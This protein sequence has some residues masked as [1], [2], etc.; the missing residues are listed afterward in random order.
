MAARRRGPETEQ[1]PIEDLSGKN[2]KGGQSDDDDKN[3]TGSGSEDS[4][5]ANNTDDRSSSSPDSTAGEE[6]IESES[7]ALATGEDEE[8]ESINDFLTSDQSWFA[9]NATEEEDLV[10][11]MLTDHVKPDDSPVR[12][13]SFMGARISLSNVYDLESGVRGGQRGHHAELRNLESMR[14][15]NAHGRHV[16]SLLRPFRNILHSHEDSGEV[17]DD[18]ASVSMH[19]RFKVQEK[20]VPQE[21][22]GQ[23]RQYHLEAVHPQ[24]RV[25]SRLANW[26]GLGRGV[27]FEDRRQG[28]CFGFSPNEIVMS[29]L[30]WSFRASFAAVFLSAALGFLGATM[31]FAFMIWRIGVRHPDCIGGVDFENDY[32]MDAFALSWTTFSTVGYGLVYSGISADKPDIKVCTGITILVTIEA[33]V[34]VLFASF[35]GAIVFGKINRIQSFA[36]VTFSDPIVI[37]Y[38]SGSANRG[39]Q[40]QRDR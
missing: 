14:P 7:E 35:C 24:M 32:F 38:G 13:S 3:A 34:G 39:R 8:M 5:P 18:N 28:I 15:Q 33:F 30:R 9:D 16:Q 26:M 22:E 20:D 2:D 27:A 40:R 23:R 21:I 11:P 10:G 25:H 17:Q 31:L 12:Q 4:E 1:D 29:Y 37:R 6:N 36:Q 19:G